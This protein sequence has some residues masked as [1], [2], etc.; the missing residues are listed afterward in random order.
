MWLSLKY[1]LFCKLSKFSLMCVLYF[2]NHQNNK[3]IINVIKISSSPLPSG[4]LLYISF[5][6]CPFQPSSL[7]PSSG[8]FI[9]HYIIPLIL[10]RAV[11]AAIPGPLGQQHH[12]FTN[13][14]RMGLKGNNSKFHPPPQKW[15]DTTCPFSA[16][17]SPFLERDNQEL[18]VTARAHR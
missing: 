4:L 2:L 14:A 9:R 15:A 18:K 10:L 8:K 16:I 13:P 7:P 5:C 12:A 6:S 17:L 3:N 1:L 11:K